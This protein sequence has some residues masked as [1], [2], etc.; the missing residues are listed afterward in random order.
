MQ[1][2]SATLSLSHIFLG[3][4]KSYKAKN[5][6]PYKQWQCATCWLSVIFA[7]YHLFLVAFLGRFLVLNHCKTECFLSFLGVFSFFLSK[8]RAKILKNYT[9]FSSINKEKRD[10]Y[11]R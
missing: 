10:C 1:S 2:N 7:K 8:N 9:K 5:S 6:T 3:E 11:E 4:G